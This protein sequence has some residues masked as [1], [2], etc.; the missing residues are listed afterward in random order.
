MDVRNELPQYSTA[1]QDMLI[2]GFLG[3]ESAKKNAY[4][5]NSKN[6]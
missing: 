4:V 1:M 5:L 2:N 3:T 6:I